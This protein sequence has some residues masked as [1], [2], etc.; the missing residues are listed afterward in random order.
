ML[1][2]INYVF[3]PLSHNF[4]FSYILFYAKLDYCIFFMPGLNEWQF[5]ISTELKKT[6]QVYTFFF[7]V[8]YYLN[9]ESHIN[10][11]HGG[12]IYLRG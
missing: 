1:L 7:P 8:Y 10:T 3:N 5:V 6:A 11:K 4:K 9:V 2:R 12:V